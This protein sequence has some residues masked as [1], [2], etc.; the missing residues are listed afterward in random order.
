MGDGFYAFWHRRAMFSPNIDLQL[1]VGGKV[2]GTNI[3]TLI[4]YDNKTSAQFSVVYYI[5]VTG[6]NINTLEMDTV[7]S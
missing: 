2:A 4:S 3:Q 7:N 6:S 5:D 1:G